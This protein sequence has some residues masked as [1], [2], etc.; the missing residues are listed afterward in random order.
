M[1]NELC[2]R[3]IQKLNKVF[4]VRK[5]NVRVKTNLEFMSHSQI[6]QLKRSQ[7]KLG[8]EGSVYKFEKDKTLSDKPSYLEPSVL[9]LYKLLMY[10]FYCYLTLEP[11][12][13]KCNYTIRILTVFFLKSLQMRRL[14][15][16]F[17]I[18]KKSN[19]ILVTLI[20]AMN[21]TILITKK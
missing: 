2:K 7:Y 18:E 13:K 5:G 1:K 20:Q 17:S 12:W 14:N 6:K 11:Y 21:D 4:S 10:E 15:K 8:F 16:L 9:E 3:R 19:L